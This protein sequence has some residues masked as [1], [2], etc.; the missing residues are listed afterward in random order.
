MM[1][2]SGLYGDLQGIIGSGLQEIEAM[3]LLA[4]EAKAEVEDEEK[5]VA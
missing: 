3:E 2:A 5:E 4:L 1:S